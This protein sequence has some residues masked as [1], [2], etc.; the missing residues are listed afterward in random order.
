MTEMTWATLRHLLAEKYDYFRGRLTRR[1]GSDDLARETLHET[2][3]RLD[4]SDEI[5]V[6]RNP[7]AYLFRT[8]I[9]VA[10]DIQRAEGRRLRHSEVKEILLIADDSPGPAREAE[11]RLDM[12]RL[13]QSI[14]DLPWRQRAILIAAR[15]SGLPHR[16]IAA[17]FGISVRMVQMEL[18]AALEFCEDRFDEN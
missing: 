7:G 17:R 18:R 5:G 13:Q 9:N 3:L 8:A 6:I 10:M 15:V 1:L 11:A 4:R 2:Y 16:D 12:Q 14:E